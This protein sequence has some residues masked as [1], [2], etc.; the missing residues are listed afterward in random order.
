VSGRQDNPPAHYG[1]CRGES[2][3]RAG[4]HRTAGGVTASDVTLVKG[5]E[6]DV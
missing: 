5:G 2:G 3:G 1:A 4:N 6:E